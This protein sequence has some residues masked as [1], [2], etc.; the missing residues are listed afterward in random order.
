MRASLSIFAHRQ[1][2]RLERRTLICNHKPPLSDHPL[3]PAPPR[4]PTNRR[5]SRRAVSAAA[6]PPSRGPMARSRGPCRSSALAC[7]CQSAPRSRRTRR[8]QL[9]TL[10]RSEKSAPPAR[11]VCHHTSRARRACLRP[12]TPYLS[13]VPRTRSGSQPGLDRPWRR[14][15]LQAT[16]VED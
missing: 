4:P 7:V 11:Y 10:T 6:A 8:P 13:V 12:I 14:P 1:Q 9:P 16:L 3:P 2:R 5:A 15:Q